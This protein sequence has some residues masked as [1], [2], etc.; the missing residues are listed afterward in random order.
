[1]KSIKKVT[2][3]FLSL[4]IGILY[5]PFGAVYSAVDPI[6]GIH[7]NLYYEIVD[8]EII[9]T[10][11]IGEPTEIKFP[12][13]IN[14]LPVTCIGFYS[15][16][17]CESL[18]SIEIP[19]SVTTIASTSFICCSNLTSIV[20][21]DS[22]TMI[23]FSAF[24][25]CSSLEEIV[26]PDSVTSIGQFAFNATKW[27]ENQPDG[28]IY[29]GKVAYTYKG[30]M[31]YDTEIILKNDTKGIAGGAFS[32]CHN[33][34][35]III[36]DS[37]T[38]IGEYSFSD[39][40]SLK[41]III[42]KSVTEIKYCTFEDC[43]SLESIEIPDSITT[44]GNC[45]FIGCTSLMSITIPNPVTQIGTI[46]LGYEYYKFETDFKKNDNFIIYSHIDSIAESYANANELTFISLDK[47]LSTGD[48]NADG[49]FNISDLITL[50]KHIL[51]IQDL[52][53]NQAKAADL[54]SDNKINSL[55]LFL[56]K[57]MLIQ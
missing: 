26:I 37:V 4:L 41:S 11:Y 17:S 49:I 32:W 13:E 24:S 44:I 21:P 48:V 46:A 36:P 45:A 6:T 39:C 16:S 27:Y 34:S 47:K 40:T 19:S 42:P 30:Q 54:N 15:F 51:G 50:K 20:I 25:A 1:M 7:E 35:S 56:I 10:G 31:D 57:R 29:A 12:E 43:I 18:T 23:G 8:E 28:L 55:D 38:C 52:Y 14:G 3:S 53:E 5:I 2:I 33:L 22:V 9:I